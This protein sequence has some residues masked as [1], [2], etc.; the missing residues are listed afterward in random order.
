M[1]VDLEFGDPQRILGRNV[2]SD[3]RTASAPRG[4]VIALLA[5]IPT[6][7]EYLAAFTGLAKQPWLTSPGRGSEADRFPVY[8][9]LA[10]QVLAPANGVP[11]HSRPFHT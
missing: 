3:Q 10:R 6:A 9:H 8:N 2:T 5:G 11:H 4:L 1:I 7:G